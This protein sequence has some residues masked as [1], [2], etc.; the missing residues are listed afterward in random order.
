MLL[1][2][3]SGEEL[4]GPSSNSSEQKVQAKSGSGVERL[5]GH[6]WRGQWERLSE[7]YGKWG[8]LK[9]GCLEACSRS[10]GSL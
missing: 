8:F 2:F 7:S 4:H 6:F 10:T 5:Q 3:F 1:S 9:L